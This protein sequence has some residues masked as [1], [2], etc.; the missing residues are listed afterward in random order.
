MPSGRTHDAITILLAAP[1]AGAAWAATGEVGTTAVLTASFLFGGLMFGP[2]LDTVSKQHPR[3]GI[4]RIIWSPYRACFRHRSRWSHGLLFGTLIRV[5]YFL[6]VLTVVS[7][8]AAYALAAYSGGDLPRIAESM[9][10]WR[11]IGDAIR[12]NLGIYAMPAAFVGMWSGAASHTITDLTGSYI[13]TG[14]VTEF[15]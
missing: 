3:W 11:L 10:A 12:L 14:R 2:D 15:L 8:G 7:F 4:F 13:K 1:V 9:S 6:G 5:V